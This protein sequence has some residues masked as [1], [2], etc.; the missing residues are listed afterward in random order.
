MKTKL[1]RE[2]RNEAYRAYGIKTKLPLPSNVTP[3]KD[4]EGVYII[5]QRF[6][7]ERDVVE[8]S[9]KSAKKRL[10]LMR[11]DYCIK[12]VKEKRVVNRKI[13]VCRI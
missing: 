13:R 2:L 5:G 12:S 11:I 3:Q 8:F 7:P 4:F 6:T 1:L 10:L 9:L